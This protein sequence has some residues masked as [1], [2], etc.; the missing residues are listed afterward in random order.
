MT[1]LLSEEIDLCLGRQW[2]SLSAQGLVQVLFAFSN[3][4]NMYPPDTNMYPN[5]AKRPTYY[6]YHHH[7]HHHLH[8]KCSNLCG[9]RWSL[10]PGTLLVTPCHSRDMPGFTAVHRRSFKKTGATR[11]EKPIPS[12]RSK[13]WH[14]DVP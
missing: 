9:C 12:R 7:H 6:D 8:L 3:D 10:H 1:A 11:V 14:P 13:A 2:L 5:Y 4:T